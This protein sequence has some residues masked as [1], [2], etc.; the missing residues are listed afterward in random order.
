MKI[1]TKEE[2]EEKV[3]CAM[4]RTRHLFFLFFLSRFHC[5]QEVKYSAAEDSL[6]GSGKGFWRKFDELVF[7]FYVSNR[8]VSDFVVIL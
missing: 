2:K 1:I 7:L 5:E 6:T 3:D 4:I 8:L